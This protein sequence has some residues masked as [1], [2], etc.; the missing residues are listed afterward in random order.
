M[1][2]EIFATN[3]ITVT[4]KF[5]AHSFLTNFRATM[6]RKKIHGTA[7]KLTTN[8]NTPKRVVTGTGRLLHINL[9]NNIIFVRMPDV[10]T[11]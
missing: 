5:V 9:Y 8:T 1:Q 4:I 3:I 6:S 11:D 2:S 10:Q 7:S